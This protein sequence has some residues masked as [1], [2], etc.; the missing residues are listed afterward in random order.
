ML[1]FVS[2][3]V[4]IMSTSASNVKYEHY[5]IQLLIVLVDEIS[6]KAKAKVLNSVPLRSMPCVAMDYGT[7]VY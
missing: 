5:E 4:M 2:P 7:S 6:D 1:N 3:F